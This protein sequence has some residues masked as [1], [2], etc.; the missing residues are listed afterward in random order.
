MLSM[1]SAI[2]IGVVAG[3]TRRTSRRDAVLAD[4]EGVRLQIRDRLLVGVE[5][6]DVEDALARLREEPRGRWAR[7]NWKGNDGES[8]APRDETCQTCPRHKIRPP[9]QFNFVAPRGASAK[10][11]L[12]P[13][14]D[15]PA[16]PFGN[17]DDNDDTPRARRIRPETAHPRPAAA[18]DGHHLGG[19]LLAIKVALRDFPQIPFN[20]LRLLLASA[21]FLAAIALRGGVV[22]ARAE[23]LRLVFLGVVGH[24]AYQLCFL[25]AGIARTSVANSSLIFGCTPV[26]VALMSSIAGHERLPPARWTGRRSLGRY[27]RRGRPRR[28]AVARDARRRCARLRRDA[29]LVAVFGCRATAARA[30]LA[31]RRDGDLDD[32]GHGVLSDSGDRSDA[33]HGLAAVYRGRAGC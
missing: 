8:R 24:L 30:S 21:V 1:M 16:C 9:P 3:V 31:A 20:A 17:L 32:A 33:A 28:R 4:D 23:W 27:H 11:S 15:T 6:V 10:V 5:D 22:L 2:G 12:Y 14:R 13:P 7:E 19:E 18:P 26:V 25:A 29:V